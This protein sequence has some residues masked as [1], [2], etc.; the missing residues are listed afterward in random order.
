MY[1]MPG[2]EKFLDL[3]DVVAQSPDQR[4]EVTICS[5]YNDDT[6][7]EK[8]AW[9]TDY[10][11]S[12]TDMKEGNDRVGLVV[13]L[14]ERDNEYHASEVLMSHS[15]KKRLFGIYADKSVRVAITF[16]GDDQDDLRMEVIGGFSNAPQS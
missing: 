8:K 3:A 12:R 6:V 7:E 11:D 14:T 15:D 9:I 1:N 13:D 16:E 10:P 5:P 4:L 2:N